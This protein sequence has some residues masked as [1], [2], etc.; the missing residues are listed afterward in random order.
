M[1]LVGKRRQ[2]GHQLALGVPLVDVLLLQD[3]KTAVCIAFYEAT[4]L[5]LF[6]NHSFR[7]WVH[8]MNFIGFGYP[9][10]F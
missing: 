7:P 1:A 10:M 6:L 9:A 4:K 8:S 5:T 3:F 2:A